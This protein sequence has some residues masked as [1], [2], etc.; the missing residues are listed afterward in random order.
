MRAYASNFFVA[1]TGD[2]SKAGSVAAPWATLS[3]ASMSVSPGDVVHVAPGVYK[4]AAITHASGAASARIAFVSDVPFGAVLQTTGAHAAWENNGDFVDI[5]GF[6]VSGDGTIGIWNFGSNV[7]IINN[8]VHDIPAPCTSVGGAGI[9]EG[10]YSGTG[11]E[12]IGNWVFRI[13]AGTTPCQ[14]VHGIY[15]TNQGTHVWNNI[16]FDNRGVGIH[17]W[18]APSHISIANNLVFE[19]DYGGISVGAGDKPGNVIADFIDVLNNIVVSNH[20]RPGIFE[21]QLTGT[22]NRYGHNLVYQND[23]DLMLLNGLSDNG[24]LLIDPALVDYQ[25]DGSGDYHLSERSPCIGAGATSDTPT[26]DIEGARRT[27]MDVGPYGFFAV[28]ADGGSGSVTAVHRGCTMDC[29]SGSDR[30]GSLL[31]ASIMAAF[32]LRRRRTLQRLIGNSTR[33]EVRSA[34]RPPKD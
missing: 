17:L 22:N 1:S 33:P 2:D 18:H 27:K 15:P 16:V 6:D 26:Q 9:D 13:G 14:F 10:D 23:G 25:P 19:N 12:I 20:N 24:T 32:L 3:R 31:L 21:V 28:L 5:V 29:R 34:D 11:D 30:P 7:R 4:D 8:R